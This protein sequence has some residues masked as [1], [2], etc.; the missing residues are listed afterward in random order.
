MTLGLAI[1]G[2]VILSE[3][4]TSRSSSH[5][6]PNW[7]REQPQACFMP[8]DFRVMAGLSGG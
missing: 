8:A 7:C 6:N 3:A 1:F 5:S 2:F 4:L